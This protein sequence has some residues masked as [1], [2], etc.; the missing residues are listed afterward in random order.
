MRNKFAGDCYRCGERVEAGAGYFERHAGGWRVQHIEC[1]KK[2]RAEA[3][4][5]GGKDAG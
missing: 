4:G 1:C 2:A 3:N 5:D